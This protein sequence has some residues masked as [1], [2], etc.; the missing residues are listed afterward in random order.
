MRNTETRVEGLDTFFERGRKLARLAVF[1]G[2]DNLL[3]VIWVGC[4]AQS[5][6]IVDS[7]P[8]E[9]HLRPSHP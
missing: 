8:H 7:R 3:G 2:Y 1:I 5:R 6:H 4:R 9:L